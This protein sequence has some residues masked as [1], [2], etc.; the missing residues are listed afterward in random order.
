MCVTNPC[1][2][3]LCDDSFC[4]NNQRVLLPKLPFF[5]KLTRK[6]SLWETFILDRKDNDNPP[7]KTEFAYA[8]WKLKSRHGH[9]RLR[10]KQQEKNAEN[11][12]DKSEVR[13]IDG[14]D[15]H[16]R[17]FCYF[18]AAEIIERMKIPVNSGNAKTI[19]ISHTRN[20]LRI[21]SSIL[22]KTSRKCA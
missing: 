18:P 17:R 3:R 5:W 12:T 19:S 14:N 11:C 21:K 13:K 9:D 4:S 8:V 1:L 22:R 16:R 20:Q 6:A 10:Q 7:L 15:K 2:A